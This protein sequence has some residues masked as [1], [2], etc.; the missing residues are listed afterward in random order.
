[1]LGLKRK[2]NFTGKFGYATEHSKE[3][4]HQAQRW[5]EIGK[6]RKAGIFRNWRELAHFSRVEKAAES[7]ALMN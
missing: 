5:R 4:A 6:S 1:V 3:S 7:I 2:G